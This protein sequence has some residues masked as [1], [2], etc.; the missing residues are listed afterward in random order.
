[1]GLLKQTE[2]QV[3]LKGVHLCCGGCVDAV[4]VAAKSV[5][6]VAVYCDMSNRTVTITA[7]DDAAVQKALDAIAAAGLHGETGNAH[8][9]MKV[10]R[11]IPPG[12]VRRLKI[13]DIHN[14]CGPCYQA[15]KDAIDSVEGVTGDT[16][17]P[18]KT[19]FEV[20]GNFD[21]AALV[22]SLNAAGFH[23]KVSA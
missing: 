12:K 2:T 9:A 5:P 21:A 13:S 16:A 3:R 22:R 19:A 18:G 8:L 4:A 7:K 6:G 14:C 17:Q 11:N 1:M 10:E 20:R 23:A 15:I